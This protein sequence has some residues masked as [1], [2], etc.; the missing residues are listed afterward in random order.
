MWPKWVRCITSS[1]RKTQ[2][3]LRPSPA[4]GRL[5][6]RVE[7]SGDEEFSFPTNYAS[8]SRQLWA[9]CS[10][11][12]PASTPKRAVPTPSRQRFWRRD[13]QSAVFRTSDHRVNFGARS[14]RVDTNLGCFKDC[15]FQSHTVLQV[16]CEFGLDKL[17]PCGETE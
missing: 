1:A 2:H 5:S 12:R 3:I 9:T 8:D 4:V 13:D 10:G 14:R 17:S 16:F 11:P 6:T 15:R 7:P